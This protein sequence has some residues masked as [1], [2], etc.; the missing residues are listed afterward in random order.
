MQKLCLKRM[1]GALPSTK[2]ESLL[3][4]LGIKS[5]DTRSDQLKL[6]FF[7]KI[8][9]FSE[10][11]YVRR[12]LVEQFNSEAVE[13]SFSA[14]IREIFW[15]YAEDETY[16]RWLPEFETLETA[17]N[18]K[19]FKSLVR[20]VCDS[21]DFKDC[22]LEVASSA[23]LSTGQGRLTHAATQHLNSHAGVL[24]I[25]GNALWTPSERTGFFQTFLGCDFLTPFSHKKKPIC[26]FC[27]HECATWPHLLLSCPR[28]LVDG[29]PRII[30]EVLDCLQPGRLRSLFQYTHDTDSLFVLLMGILEI[31]DDF[32][33]S[34]KWKHPLNKVTKITAQHI[35]KVHS[36]WTNFRSDSVGEPGT[37]SPSAG[38]GLQEALRG[39]C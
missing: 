14:N 21:V 7:N 23:F 12:V 38:G 10:D 30:V 6:N 20:K 11:F 1:C 2:Y 25:L 16:C 31:Q 8:K 28:A 15:E 29:R 22:C 5:M 32:S 39:Q 36:E 13:H 18:P 24:Q 34:I 4:S 3:L 19:M 17:L 9:L 37:P 35:Q 33:Y 26:K 27:G